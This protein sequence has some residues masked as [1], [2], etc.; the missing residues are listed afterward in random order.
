MPKKKMVREKVCSNSIF[1]G[2]ELEGP[3]NELEEAFKNILER[4]CSSDRYGGG[5]EE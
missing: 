3:I 1:M 5:E 4:V 2:Y